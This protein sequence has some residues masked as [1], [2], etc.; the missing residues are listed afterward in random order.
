MPTI[1]DGQVLAWDSAVEQF[2]PEYVGSLPPGPGSGYELAITPGTAAQYWRGDKTW[3]A[4]NVAAVSGLQ[5]ALDLKAPLASPTFTGTPTVNGTAFGTAAFKNTGTASGDIPLLGSGGKLAS[6]VLPAI[7]I[8]DTFV[9]ASQAAMLAL[10]AAE[11][12]DVA[13]R[14]DLN[15]SFILA[16]TNPATLAHWQELL[17]PTDAVLS[18]NGQTGAV[19]LTKSD[20]GLSNVSNDAQLKIASNLSDLANAATA[21]TNLGVAI[22]THVQAYDPTLTALA[23]FNSNGLLVQT[24]ADTF[25]ARTLTGTANQVTVSNGDGV[26]GNPTLSLPQNIHAGASPTFAGLSL[27]G[28]LL[29][30]NGT[31][32]NPA[33]AFSAAAN[34]GIYARSTAAL[35]FSSQ[36]T[37]RVE[38]EAAALGLASNVVVNWKSGALGTGADTSL[39]RAA[40]GVL[41]IGDGAANANG[42]LRA[43]AV[44]TAATTF[45][46]VNATATTINFGGAATALNMGAAGGT[47]AVAGN[48][49]AAGVASSL[50][51][52][53]TDTYDLGSSLK[54]WRK[55]WLSELDAVL[56]AQNTVSLIGG[57]LMATK[58]EGA[59]PVGQD[60]GAG[61]A[62]IDF[63]QAM[64]PNDFVLFRSAGSVEYVQVG[65]LSSGTRYNVTRNL[66]GSGANAWVAGSVYAVLGNTTNGRIE[67]NANATP[68]ISLIKQGAAYNAQTELARMGDLNGNWGY[69]SE[70]YGFAAGEYAAGKNWVSVDPTNGFRIGLHNVV[71]GQWDSTGATFGATTGGNMR[72][73][74]F[75][76]QL[77]FRGGTTVQAYIDTAGAFRSVAG[78]LKIDVNG[79]S[80]DGAS[81]NAYALTDGTNSTVKLTGA[82]GSGFLSAE[83]FAGGTVGGAG[84]DV[85]LDLQADAPTALKSATTTLT[86]SSTSYG[87]IVLGVRS[88]SSGLYGHINGALA[89]NDIA[90]PSAGYALDVNGDARVNGII[91]VVTG[92]RVNGAATSGHVL[93]GNGTNFISAQ[94]AA[95][96]LSNGAT[97]S[98]AVVLAT[99]PTVTALNFSSG[100][101]TSN[102]AFGLYAGS[103]SE[104]DIRYP[105]SS[106]LRF[107][108]GSSFGDGASFQGF[109][110]L[111]AGLPGQMYFDYGSTARAI[112][113]RQAVWRS[114]TTGVTTDVMILNAAGALRLNAYGAGTL[115][116]DASGNITAT[117]DERLKD[118]K[119]KFTEGLAALLKIEPITY[120]WK[121]ETGLDTANDYHGFSAQNVKKAVPGACGK[122]QDDSLTIQE[123][124]LMAVV[125]NAVK[126]LAGEISAMKKLLPQTQKG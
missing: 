4:L 50:I 7:A 17:T 9:V 59:I 104:F 97:G 69:S 99:S 89:I 98:G 120:R 19:A 27:T 116:T 72:W 13:V 37:G 44:T 100:G 118:V 117:S 73:D 47:V 49:S 18:V 121:K 122:N 81:G 95:S 115:T 32:A 102:F 82:Y 12:G 77:Q 84:R 3:Q 75:S 52:S 119:A 79:V 65:T 85:L 2:I 15:K 66:D 112:A 22:G 114:M 30:P 70:T 68:R 123:R 87:T 5:T 31:P 29:L 90:A 60:V 124:A 14:S 34:L 107:S 92:Y 63:G 28:A 58:S 48:L 93:R 78:A 42:T 108:A 51:P 56:F 26:S 46:L 86:A 64:T 36:G 21:R 113:G 39:S 33:L 126:E 57:W 91:N 105:N 41:Q 11:T 25:A 67:I 83:L 54:L 43:A 45:G 94:L 74:N 16:G 80:L 96:D 1:E 109:G 106:A 8:T 110:G 111:S 62:T 88:T 23:A 6:S 103:G 40:A 61:D 71:N 20:V 76:G 10:S 38:V 35:T 101:N 53:A 24:A 55:G 125:V